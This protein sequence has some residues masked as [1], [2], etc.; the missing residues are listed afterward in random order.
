M[1][2][3]KW[4][5]AGLT[6]LILRVFAYASGEKFA[7]GK[8]RSSY[9][10]RWRRIAVITALS[11]YET[12]SNQN[13][14]VIPSAARATSSHALIMVAIRFSDSWGGRTERPIRI[15][16]NAVWKS[17]SDGRWASQSRI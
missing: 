13:S 4:Q 10:C 15:A 12:L 8:P 1:P 14:S 9:F 3:E 17:S 2:G 16:S 7:A 6:R 5:N 11:A